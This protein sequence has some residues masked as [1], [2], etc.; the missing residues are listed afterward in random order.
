MNKEQMTEEDMN[1]LDKTADHSGVQYPA[2]AVQDNMKRLQA[3]GKVDAEG[4]LGQIAQMAH[5][6][7]H[8]IVCSQILADGLG[9][10]GRLH[11][12]EILLCHMIL[13]IET[14]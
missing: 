4:A 1:R 7:L 8:G 3:E 11:D 9:L 13:H 10:G 6:G 5:T 2:S 14:G 12:H